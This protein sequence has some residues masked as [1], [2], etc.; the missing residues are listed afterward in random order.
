MFPH[1]RFGL[2]QLAK[3]PGFACVAV[4]SLALGIGANTAVFSVMNAV[5]LAQLPVKEPERLAIFNWIAEE[6]VFPLSSS[7]W[8]TTEPGSKKLTSTSF[9]VPTFEAFR[10]NASQFSEIF[11]FSPTGE[12]NVNVDGAAETAFGQVASGNYHT[13]LGVAAAI[14]RLFSPEDDRAGAEPVAVISHRYWQRRFGGAA[15]AIGKTITI[16][17]AP[18]TVIGVTAPA[19]TGTLQVGEV[20]D[21]T[22]PLSLEPRVVRRFGSHT[23]GNWWLRIMGR[24]KPGVS[25]E[26]AR[27]SLAGVFQETARNNVRV[28]ALPGAPAV[29][30][31]HVP[32]PL[33]RTEPGGRGLYEARRS[34]EK[35]L[36]LLIGVVGLVLLVACA[37]VANLLLTRGA[38]RR[39][40]IAVRLALGA[41][42][43][44]LVAQLLTENALLAAFGALGGLVFALW[45]ARALVALQPFGARTLELDLSLDWR[46]LG[47]ASLMALASALVFGLAPALRA[48]RLNLTGEFQGGVRSLGAGS[49][50]TLAKSLMVVQVALSLVLLVGAGLFLRTLRNLQ[51]VDVGFNREQLLLFTIAGTANGAAGPQATATYDRMLERISALPGVRRASY[52]RV[53]PLSHNNWNTGVYVPGYSPSTIADSNSRMNGVDP[54]YFSTMELPL[55]RGRAFD[56]RDGATAPRVAIVNQAFARKFFGTEDVVGRRIGTRRDQTTEPKIEIVGLVRDSGYSEIRDAVPPVTFFPYSQLG[57]NNRLEANFVVRFAGSEGAVVSAIRAAAREVDANLPVDNV[58]TQQQQIDRLFTQERLFANLCSVFGGLA[59]LLSAV[60]LYG[61]MSYHVLRR[62]SEIGLRMALGAL[63][64]NVLGMILRESLVLVAL[65]VAVGSVSALG[66]TRWIASLLFGLS[67]LDPVTYGCVAALLLTIAT[68]ACLLPARRAAKI[69]PM[70]ALRTE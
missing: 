70:T 2:R 33:L 19:F 53:A 60:G 14:G 22:L 32:L 50:S 25:L 7:G 49:K 58:R 37:N 15:D 51:N 35:S 57:E 28:H 55:L 62:T 34:Y 38:A 24:L 31:A 9:S 29:D 23:A 44:R 30:P 46:V 36:Q 17:G 64:A 69:D 48:T 41:S 54:G 10:A 59:L 5:L 20:A 13:G 68:V 61:L 42:R 4:L 45:G 67:P 56:P 8:Q 66:A 26:Q 65:G 16:N 27:S 63:P 52:A 39:R 11:G 43:A 12:L 40:E 6:N 47:F 21:V 3:S 18:I 1:L